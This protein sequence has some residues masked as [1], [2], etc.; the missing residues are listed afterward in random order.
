[1]PIKTSC[2]IGYSGLSDTTFLI[3]ETMKKSR[4]FALP[5]ETFVR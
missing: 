2:H 4:I 5:T 1:M 3:S